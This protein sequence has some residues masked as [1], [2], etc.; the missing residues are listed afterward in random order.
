MQRIIFRIFLASFLHLTIPCPFTNVLPSRILK[1]WWFI[2]FNLVTLH[3]C[4][5]G[6]TMC[7]F[8]ILGDNKRVSSKPGISMVTRSSCILMVDSPTD[9]ILFPSVQF[10]QW[11]WGTLHQHSIPSL[12]VV[13]P[14]SG[15]VTVCPRTSVSDPSFQ[16]SDSCSL[17]LEPSDK[18]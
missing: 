10:Q 16:S 9:N 13:K 6:V 15:Q 18:F 14:A 1:Y 3:V 7:M 17:V 8:Y 11:P 12:E 5:H 4:G 2:K